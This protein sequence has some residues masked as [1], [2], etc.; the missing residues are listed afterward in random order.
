[1]ARAA[2]LGLGMQ[3]LEERLLVEVGLRLDELLVD[4]RE[5]GVVRERERVVDR[6][7]DRVARVPPRVVD[8]A[9]RMARGAGDP[10][11]RR[12][13]VGGGH[14]VVAPP[15]DLAVPDDQGTKGATFVGFHPPFGQG[16]GLP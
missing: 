13:I 15:D 7:V 16:D 5:H 9:D 10:G 14:P 11:V 1:M 6:R 3:R 12:G 8:R 4:P 2:E